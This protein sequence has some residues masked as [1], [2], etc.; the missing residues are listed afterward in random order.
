M[1]HIKRYNNANRPTDTTTRLAPREASTDKR[2]SEAQAIEDRR[3]ENTHEFN[4]SNCTD[5]QPLT[6]TPTAAYTVLA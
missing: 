2:R 3:D 1:R 6:S 5:S 4:R